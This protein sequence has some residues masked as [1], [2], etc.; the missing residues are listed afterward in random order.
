MVCHNNDN[1]FGELFVGFDCLKDDFW[2]VDCECNDFL[3]DLF[4]LKHLPL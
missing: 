4:L 2:Y 1:C 3:L